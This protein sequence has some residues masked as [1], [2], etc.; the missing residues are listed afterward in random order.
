MIRIRSVF[1]RPSFKTS[2]LLHSKYINTLLL[3]GD[4]NIFRLNVTCRKFHTTHHTVGKSSCE[5]T[6][7]NSDSTWRLNY[8]VHAVAEAETKLDAIISKV[9]NQSLKQVF[10]I[11]TNNCR[12]SFYIF[13]VLLANLFSRF[14]T[15]RCYIANLK[16]FKS[17]KIQYSRNV[18]KYVCLD[19]QSIPLILCIARK[20]FMNLNLRNQ[21]QLS[22]VLEYLFGI[23]FSCIRQSK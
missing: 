11:F 16:G 20:I 10:Y 21:Y 9:F 12:Q 4:R 7:L 6:T 13:D 19:S 14:I 8:E 1:C 2:K 17:I 23:L 15:Y 22:I 18:E 3:P 5:I